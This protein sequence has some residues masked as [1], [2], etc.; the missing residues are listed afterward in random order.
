MLRYA[1]EQ[2]YEFTM[3]IGDKLSIICNDRKQGIHFIDLGLKLDVHPNDLESI[4]YSSI[5]SEI[6]L[7]IRGGLFG[8]GNWKRLYAVLTNI[9]ILLFDIKNQKHPCDL[10]PLS[11]LQVLKDSGNQAPYESRDF[12]LKLQ[13]NREEFI[14]STNEQANLERW[15]R[16]IIDMIQ[17]FKHMRDDYLSNGR[18]DS[19]RSKSSF[20]ASYFN[21]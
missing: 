2:Q 3:E 4:V 14:L 8:K 17:D 15:R 20:M 1:F 7:Y 13:N 19:N 5:D 16:K 9:G 21:F 18:L 11:N 10:I 6:Y 12:I